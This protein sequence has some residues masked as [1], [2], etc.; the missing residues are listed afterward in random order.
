[1]SWDSLRKFGNAQCCSQIHAT[2]AEWRSGIKSCWCEQRACQPCKCWWKIF[3]YFF[4]FTKLKSVLKG[5]QLSLSR[6]FKKIHYQS[7]AVFQKR[8]S[9]NA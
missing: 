6:K 3:K 7:Y 4:L 2:P 5:Q 1:V 9:R 8:H